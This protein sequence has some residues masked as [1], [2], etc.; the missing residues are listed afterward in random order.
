MV[1]PLEALAGRAVAQGYC[2][3][4]ARLLAAAENWR[5]TTGCLLPPAL[6]VEHSADVALTKQGLTAEEFST[7]WA[8]GT[9]LTLQDAVDYARRGRGPRRRPSKGLA[10]LTPAER[11]IADLVAEG[12]TNPEIAQ[13]L[14]I[15]PRT[16]QTHVSHAL[17]KL[18]VSSRRELAKAVR[19][20]T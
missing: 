10:S 2:S 4:A 6:S 15:S 7:A 3:N 13:R 17:A 16:V 19:G 9:R 11:Q 8:E 14:F 18:G 1:G 12:L 20:L 5:Q